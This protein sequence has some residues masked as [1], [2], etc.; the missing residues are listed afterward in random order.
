MNDRLVTPHF[1]LSELC[2][3]CCRKM[4]MPQTM[5]DFIERV[6]TGLGLKM[7]LN[8]ACRCGMHNAKVGGKITSAHL[9]GLAIDVFCPSEV[10]RFKLLSVAFAMGAQG[11]GIYE[12]AKD[13]SKKFVHLDLMNRIAG[14]QT[15]VEVS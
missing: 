6:R 14:P 10:Y 4:N 8:S 3:P 7:K 9:Q 5:L 2:C 1:K 13:P 12:N 15:W 11:V